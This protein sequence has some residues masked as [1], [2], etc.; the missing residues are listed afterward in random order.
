[1]AMNKATASPFERGWLQRIESSLDG[2]LR[3]P[4]STPQ[5]KRINN[6][7]NTINRINTFAKRWTRRTGGS[8]RRL[9]IVRL[10]GL[11]LI[12]Y[13]SQRVH[14]RAT[15]SEIVSDSVPT[16]MFNA[17]VGTLSFSYISSHYG[18]CQSIM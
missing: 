2:L 12:V 10:A 4:S 3:Q 11:L 16:G 14:Q 7:S 5:R 18:V 1:M 15:V 8:Y 13:V 9:S 6:P 17:M